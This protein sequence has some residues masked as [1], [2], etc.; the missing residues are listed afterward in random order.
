MEDKPKKKNIAQRGLATLGRHVSGRAPKD[1]SQGD[2][3]SYLTQDEVDF[4]T[5]KKRKK[6]ASDELMDK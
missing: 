5:G 3:E 6:K 1:G 2:P 4:F